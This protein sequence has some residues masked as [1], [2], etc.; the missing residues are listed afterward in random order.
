MID[1]RH[2][3]GRLAAVARQMDDHER[4]VPRRQFIEN[5]GAAVLAAVVDQ[6]QFIRDVQFARFFRHPGVEFAHV[7]ALVVDGNDDGKHGAPWVVG[8]LCPKRVNR[9]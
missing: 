1:A 4:V 3:G 8:G 2:E 7:V 6:Q 5:F 9:G